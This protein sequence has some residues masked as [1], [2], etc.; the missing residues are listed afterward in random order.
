MLDLNNINLEDLHESSFNNFGELSTINIEGEF[1]FTDFLDIH[2]LSYKQYNILS[3]FSFN[4]VVTK[5]VHY[6]YINGMM[7]ELNQLNYGTKRYD[8][9]SPGELADALLSCVEFDDLTQEEKY[10]TIE[11]FFDAIDNFEAKLYNVLKVD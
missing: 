11:L 5:N 8:I 9:S 7:I 6:H 1:R 3:A 2:S 10:E 4:T